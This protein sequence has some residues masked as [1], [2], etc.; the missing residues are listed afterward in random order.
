MYYKR[1]PYIV[2][3]RAKGARKDNKDIGTC[4]DFLY[5]LLLLRL[6]H[7]EITPE[8]ERAATDI[9]TLLGQL[10]D[11]YFKLEETEEV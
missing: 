3:L 11:Y 1:L 4:M 5:G 6:Q 2:E 10:S 8:T 9:T 7:K